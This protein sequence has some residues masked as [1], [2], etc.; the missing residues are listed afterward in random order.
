MTTPA[1]FVQFTYDPDTQ[2]S[3][4]QPP[5]T[6]PSADLGPLTGLEGVW[7]GPGFNQIWRPNFDPQT[8]ANDRFL[9]L[10]VTA[11]TLQFNTEGL[12]KIPNRGLLQGDIEMSGIRY[13]QTIDDTSDGAGLHLEPGLWLTVP[14]TTEPPVPASVAR[15]AS[16]PHGTTIVAQG[17]AFEVPK[18]QFD[19]ASI[20]PFVIDQPE[21]LINFPEEDLSVNSIFRT[22]ELAAKGITQAMVTN[23]NSVLETAAAPNIVKTEVLQVSSLPSPILG[24]GTAN[25]AFLEGQPGK[26]NAD[27]ASVT[28]IF[29]L[30]TLEGESRPTQ[31][32][33]TQTV[34][35]NFNGLSWPHITVA[36]LTLQA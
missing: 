23:P 34:L 26:P 15:L 27:A 35:L 11:E 6:L 19:L 28:A 21:N 25:T 30:E 7:K 2:P 22:P 32:Q 4:S 13:L 17:T 16:I 18:P 24:G 12:G 29:W 20:T 1:Q 14:A 3:P 31:L 8:P 10:N 5:G 9:E 36:T 33:Y